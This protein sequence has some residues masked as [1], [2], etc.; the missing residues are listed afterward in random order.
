VALF[1][2]QWDF[3]PDRSGPVAENG[4]VR[5]ERRVRAEIQNHREAIR[6]KVALEAAPSMPLMV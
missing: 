2:S 6:R 4:E 3:P 1:G 5:C